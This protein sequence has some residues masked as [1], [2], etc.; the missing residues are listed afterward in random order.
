MSFWVAGAVIGGAAIGAYGSNSAA[1]TQAAGQTQAANTQAG[2]FGSIQKLNQPYVSGG[3]G[4]LSQLLYGS[5]DTYT[6]P[7][8]K[9]ISP[10]AGGNLNGV[11]A[12]QFTS[13]FTP[14]DLTA[15]LSP[16]YAFQLQQGG[17]AVRNADTPTQGALSGG[18]LKDLMSFNQGLASTS[19]QQAYNNWNN[20]NNTIFGRLSAIA[21]LGQNAASGVG[22]AGTTLGTGVAQAQAGAAASQAGGI[23]GATNAIGNSTTPLAYLLSGQNGQNNDAASQF[24]S[25][26]GQVVGGN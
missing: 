16:G 1:N 2:M 21:G 26:A 22:N 5:G 11:G 4:A 23:V 14:A 8:G 19:Y 9:T 3:Y 10:T 18:S 12:N 7:G 17:Q 25:G 15:N 20:T 6:G 13:Q 24:V